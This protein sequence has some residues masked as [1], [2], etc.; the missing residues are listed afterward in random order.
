MA[1]LD[2]ITEEISH[3][4]GFFHLSLEDARQRESYSDFSF[5]TTLHG[6]ASR[7]IEEAPFAAP[8]A[9]D[10]YDPILNYRP[11]APVFPAAPAFYLPPALLD[12]APEDLRIEVF[13]R[14]A[15]LRTQMPFS[16]GGKATA[17]ALEPPG[18]L[19]TYA[20]QH[21]VLSDN[22][23]FSVGGHG[24][25]ISGDPIALAD[26]LP[27]AE[28]LLAVSPLGEFE[29]PGSAAEMI[30]LVETVAESLEHLVDG[31]GSHLVAQAPTLSG[32]YVNGVA[33]EQ[34]PS[35]DDYHSFDEGDGATVEAEWG[36]EG[37]QPPPASVT[38][39]MGDNTLVNDVL[40]K[41]LWTAAKVT[42]VQGDHVE[43][44]AV[45]QINAIW[46]TDSIG[47]AVAGWGA[48]NSAND[49]FN[50]AS[51]DHDDSAGSQQLAGASSPDLYPSF[52]NVTTVNGDLMIVNWIEQLIFMSDADMG[53]VS[54]SG[55]YSTIISGDNTAVNHTTIAELGFGYDLIIIGG[56]VYDANIIQQVNVLFD[57]DAV[58]TTDGF[59][60]AGAGSVSASGNL[61]WNQ[62]SIYTI[63]A[64]DRF[65]ELSDAYRDAVA[66]LQSGSANLSDD[67][68]HDPAFAGLAGLR[69]LHV[70]GDYINVQ[71][72]KQTSIIGDDD[73][74]LL[75]MDAL[76][77]DNDASWTV[78]TG[79]NTLINN[80]AILDLDSFGKTYV[81]GEQYSQETLI[82]ANFISSQP[83]LAGHDP[84]MLAT[85]AVLFLDDTMLEADPAPE[86]GSYLP[87]DSA[88]GQDDGLQTLL[89]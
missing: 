75:A 77:P 53:I 8:H 35:L 78:Q 43:V 6:V 32:T 1:V 52:W 41:N 80:A 79:G 10:D 2:Q 46:D 68:L 51:F 89:A 64:A 16:T 37:S 55:A 34:A 17:P 30:D 38:I 76:T 61:L 81:S 59:E 11:V 65:G 21:V 45:V 15:S 42:V 87:A 28:P 4:V 82:Q 33:A 86:G 26:L 12:A 84:G 23:V 58:T 29:A 47:S 40:V 50:I 31:A 73:Q 67:I 85:E 18:S 36:G 74:I 57:T 22:D 19:V 48:S 5:K 70:Q 62:A 83:E 72:I 66:S 20:Q 25:S 27:M 39:T 54:A 14:E 69:V 9:L 49:L 24:F 63:G 60:T 7:L 88:G 3:F 44:N 13:A 56:S 71:Y